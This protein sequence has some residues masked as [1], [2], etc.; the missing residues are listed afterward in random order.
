MC[1]GGYLLISSAVMN[2]LSSVQRNSFV[3]LMEKLKST[4]ICNIQTLLPVFLAFEKPES[5]FQ[6]SLVNF[7]RRGQHHIKRAEAPFLW[8]SRVPPPSEN[9]S[10][11]CQPSRSVQCTDIKELKRKGKRKG[12]ERPMTMRLTHGLNPKTV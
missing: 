2:L 10:G 12:M 6:T 3:K 8:C 9:L 4:A 11:L 7:C 5:G 1:T